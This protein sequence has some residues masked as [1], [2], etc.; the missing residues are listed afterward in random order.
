MSDPA[1]LV[2]VPKQY[3]PASNMANKTLA[4]LFVAYVL[5]FIDRQILS[6]LIGPIREAF[7]ISD[8]QFSLLHG[9]AFAIFYTVLGLPIG[10]AA[11]RF[12]RKRIIIFG[13]FFWSIA[14]CLCALTKNFSALFAARVGVG[15][16]EAAL[17]P[18]AYS[19]LSDYFSP[20]KLPAA[21]ALYSMGITIGGGLAYIIGG[22]VYQYF[23]S[24][25]PILLPV[26]GELQAWQLTFVAVGAPGFIVVLLLGY[27][28]EPPRLGRVNSSATSTLAGIEEVLQ[29]LRRFKRAYLGHIVG[30]S[31]LSIVGYG[32]MAWFIEFLFRSFA[33]S[34]AE[35]GGIFGGMFI[36]IGSIGTFAI[37][38]LTRHLAHR[39]YTDASMRI[40][41]IV[42]LAM[43]IPAT[44]SPLMPTAYLALALASGTIFCQFGYFGVAT[45]ALQL[46][47]PNQMRAQ[48][49]ALLLFA[50]NLIGLTI[51]PA[52]VAFCTD[53][54][55]QDDSKLNYSLSLVVVIFAPLAALVVWSGLK[56]FRRALAA[57][58][59]WQ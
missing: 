5:S 58:A 45:A 57:R 53:F 8:F 11:D 6:V 38:A 7:S 32:T 41:M 35:S 23:A 26:V 49:S 43:I 17:S 21:M 55:F 2:K 36:V 1:P 56:D 25:G 51:G 50:T 4:L 9:F 3:Y 37:A 33:M 24:L 31:I 40:I 47:T 46:I 20:E 13:V 22:G 34:K 42:A 18:P 19:M 39:G 29:H 48:V 10:W 12:N 14:T 15:V 44:L 52:V 54:I 16:G 59:S 30:V 28:D 27:I